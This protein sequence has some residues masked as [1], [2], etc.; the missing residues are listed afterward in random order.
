MAIATVSFEYRHIYD[1]RFGQESTYCFTLLYCGATIPANNCRSTD[2]SSCCITPLEL[3]AIRHSSISDCLSS[4]SQNISL[5]P[6][7]TR[8]Y[9]LITLRPRG[10]CSSFA[11]LATLK[12]FDWHWH[13]LPGSGSILGPSTFVWRLW[14]SF[15]YICT[16]VTKH[17]KMVLT[18]WGDAVQ[19]G[20]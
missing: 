11:I 5:L 1:H 16:S 8:H 2:I 9:F 14:S 3:I 6:V 15:S 19:W 10:L 13:W 20:R 12:I 17:Y 18:K 7:F 4:T